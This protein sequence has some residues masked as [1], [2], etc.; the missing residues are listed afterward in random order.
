MACWT[1]RVCLYKQGISIAVGIHANDIEKMPRSLPFG[2]KG[3][4]RAA[5][6]GDFAGGNCLVKRLAVHIPEHQHTECRGILHDDRQ[7]TVSA[8]IKFKLVE[9]HIIHEDKDEDLFY[10]IFQLVGAR[11]G[12]GGGGGGVGGGGG[13]G[14]GG[15]AAPGGR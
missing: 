13:G 15:A 7:Q 3:L 1:Y 12:G 11:G 6:E 5:V 4:A 14:G 9:I 2:P 8:F 10:L